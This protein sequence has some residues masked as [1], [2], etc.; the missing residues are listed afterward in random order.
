MLP[1]EI[2]VEMLNA[3]IGVSEGPGLDFKESLPL[4]A[5]DDKKE[6]AAD[7]VAFAN[8]DGGEILIGVTERRPDGERLGVASAITGVRCQPDATIL[9][10]ES[11][12]RDGIVPR[13]AGVRVSA[14]P[15]GEE[16]YVFVVRIPRS[17]NGPHMVAY[18]DSRFFVRGNRGKYP[19]DHAQIRAAFAASATRVEWLR[20]FRDERIGRVIS[21]TTPVPLRAMPTF[22]THVVPTE[23]LA[24]AHTMD[25]RLFEQMKSRLAEPQRM[26]TPQ[27][28]YNLDGFCISQGDGEARGYVQCFRNGLIEFADCYYLPMN[29]A[30]FETSVFTG[31]FESAVVRQVA[32]SLDAMHVLQ[33]TAPFYV[34]VSVIGVK[35]WMLDWWDDTQGMF[36][37]FDRDVLTLP[38]V[39]IDDVDEEFVVNLKPVFDAYWQSAG[40]SHSRSFKDGVWLG[41]RDD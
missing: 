36:F 7:V 40:A 20:S 39:A 16:T 23:A 37:R 24:P 9:S 8:A 22:L 12:I 31:R 11:V 29:A 14:V 33:L 38:D 10:L 6:F 32:A 19:L 25:P 34:F 41:G 30:G 21:R 27:T 3:L 35:G 5:R 18:G 2:T 4:L 13:L 17:W 1:N 26:S 28:R 15:V